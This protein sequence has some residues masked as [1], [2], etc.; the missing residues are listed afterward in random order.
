MKDLRVKQ[1]EDLGLK[2]ALENLADQ[3]A[4]RGQF[5]IQLTFPEMLPESSVPIE[6]VY[7]RIAQEALENIVKHAEA[8]LVKLSLVV[9]DSRYI[10]KIEDNGIGFETLEERSSDTLGLQGMQER[11]ADCGGDLSVTSEPGKGTCIMIK[12]E[13]S[14]VQDFVMR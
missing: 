5:D 3:A 9:Q 1:V 10:L 12:T 13:L 4:A 11:A 8:S 14:H 2:L 6:Q 7:Y